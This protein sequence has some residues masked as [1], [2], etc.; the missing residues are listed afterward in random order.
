[1]G[2]YLR[3]LCGQSYD[4]AG[5]DQGAAAIIQQVCQW[6]FIFIVQ[7]MLIMGK[8]ISRPE[9]KATGIAVEQMHIIDQCRPQTHIR[10]QRM[11]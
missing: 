9:M 8:C 7:L 10:Q 6:H 5:M 11:D 3:Y 1:M 4:G 2:W